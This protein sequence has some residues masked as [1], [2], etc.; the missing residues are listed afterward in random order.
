LE[1][2]QRQRGVV[3]YADSP[4]G[5]LLEPGMVNGPEFTTWVRDALGHYWGG[6]RLADSPLL[7]L[8]IVEQA[9]ADHGGNPT[10]ALRAVLLRAIEQQRPE[11][12]RK[13]TAAEWLLY[14]ILDLKFIQGHRVRDIAARLAMSES[15]LYRKQRI[16]IETVARALADMER[17]FGESQVAGN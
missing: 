5:T 7:E 10:R 14:N 12:E 17:Q 13:M 11:G 1:V 6:P 15:D 3:R 8:K 9:L 4:P 16:A 2:I